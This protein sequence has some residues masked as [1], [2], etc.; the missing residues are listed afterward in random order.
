MHMHDNALSCYAARYDAVLYNRFSVAVAIYD[1]GIY[2]SGYWN[3]P[4]IR[5]KY[6]DIML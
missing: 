6:Y 2:G 5:S 3:A 1:T 4:D